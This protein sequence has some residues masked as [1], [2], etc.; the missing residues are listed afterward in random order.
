MFTRLRMQYHKMIF[1]LHNIYFSMYKITVNHLQSAVIGLQLDVDICAELLL[2]S[3]LT[4]NIYKHFENCP[5]RMSTFPWSPFVE[6]FSNASLNQPA[7]KFSNKGI[8]MELFLLVAQK[9][10]MRPMSLPFGEKI[11]WSWSWDKIVNDVFTHK[12]DVGFCSLTMLPQRIVLADFTHFYFIN[13]VSWVAPRPGPIHVSKNVVRVFSTDLWIASCV[14]FLVISGFVCIAFRSE[15]GKKVFFLYRALVFQ[16]VIP[17]DKT[18]FMI[19]LLN[20]VMFCSIICM[21]YQSSLTSFLT[22]PAFEPPF[23]DVHQ[24]FHSDLALL[25]TAAEN[26][27]LQR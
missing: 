10:K 14:V 12:A 18:P 4:K 6:K 21:A 25:Y 9:L 13:A 20:W 22:E 27:Y 3:S 17:A 24:L 23:E 8:E 16:P 26:D 11:I 19:L 5:L 7:E 1:Y 15:S 2:P